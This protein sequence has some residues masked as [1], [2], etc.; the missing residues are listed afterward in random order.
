MKQEYIRANKGTYTNQLINSL[1]KD[2]DKNTKDN[3]LYT[4]TKHNYFT[5]IKGQ[6]LVCYYN[7]EFTEANRLLKL[8]IDRLDTVTTICKTKYSKKVTLSYRTDTR[9]TY[10]LTMTTQGGNAGWLE[11]MTRANALDFVD[12]DNSELHNRYY[13]LLPKLKKILK[14]KARLS[15]SK[16]RLRKKIQ[17]PSQRNI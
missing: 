8:Q 17:L 11:G 6:L 4:L 13:R 2:I 10:G 9:L 15:A 16:Y 7:Q 1:T 14:R 3:N 12:Y 5:S